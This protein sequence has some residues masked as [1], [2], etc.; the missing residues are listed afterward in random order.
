MRPIIFLLSGLLTCTP[1]SAG[2]TAAQWQADLDE[3]VSLIETHHPDPYHHVS[4]ERFDEQVKMISRGIP[5]AGPIEIQMEFLMLVSMLRD[6]HTNLHPTDPGGFNHWLPLYFYGFSDGFYVTS[7]TEPYKELFG[8]RILAI[9][10]T[11]I[12]E[13]FEATADFHASDSDMGRLQNTYYM[14][15][16]DVLKAL[17]I[18]GS[19]SSVEVTYLNED[20]TKGKMTVE[21][22]EIPYNLQ[23]AKGYGEMYGPADRELFPSYYMPYREMNV[24]EWR[25]RSV[26]GNSDIPHYLRVRSG[27]WFDYLA[28]EKTMYLAIT[29]STHNERNGFNSFGDFLDQVFAVLDANPVEKVIVDVRYNPGGDG[30]VTLP[31]VHEFIKRE[32]INQPGRLFV[33]VGRK[34]YS[35]AQMI[36]AEMLK[37]THALLVGEPP[38]A[39]VNGYGDPGTYHLS[40]SEMELNISNA[41]WQ[42]GHPNDESWYPKIDL[43]FEFSGKEYVQGKDRAME[44]LLSLKAPYQNLPQLLRKTSVEQFQAE[45][46]RRQELF[47]QYSWW[48]SFNEGDMRYAARE[49]YDA[50]EHEK[51]ELG[52]QTLV[53]QY[54]ESWRAWRDYA[55]RLL[56]AGHHEKARPLIEAGLRVNPGSSDLQA[57][58]AALPGS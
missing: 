17:T 14:S 15:S 26:E 4:E 37:H 35:A 49:L 10:C 27:Y 36:Y 41:Y 19:T 40:N 32:N 55:A 56:K 21:A 34:T 48:K 16:L 29:Y 24:S 8:K 38:G 3:L 58:K 13:V 30:S 31:L 44:Y 42:M 46:A 57:L 54:P 22:V 28:D 6:R 45:A 18:T 43:P 33:L 2:L 11:A 7:A 50:G 23:N 9:G 20:G 12:E 47:G 51:G 39:P 25:S 52:F 1:L 5:K 53:K